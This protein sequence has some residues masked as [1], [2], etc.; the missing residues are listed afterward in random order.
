MAMTTT[1]GDILPLKVESDIVV[2]RQTMRRITVE[3]GFGLIDQTKFVTAASELARNTIEHGGGGEVLI[4][5]LQDGMRRGLRATF[6]D[7]G[8][9]IADLK[10]ALTDGYTTGKGMGLGLGGSRRLV[11]DF[12]ITSIV[13]QGTRVAIARWR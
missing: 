4:E 9:G 5:R 12:D 11:N 13:G 8:P 3:L 7:N 1:V 6:I 2:T 10:L